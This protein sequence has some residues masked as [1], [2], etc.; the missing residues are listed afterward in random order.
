M[1]RSGMRLIASHYLHEA[2]KYPWHVAGLFVLPPLGVF[3]NAFASTYIASEI[4]DTLSRTGRVPL[5]QIWDTFGTQIIL[6]FA[7]IIAGELIIWRL[8]L[9]VV[10]RLEVRVQFA[11]FNKCFEYL[12]HQSAQFH[13]NKFGGS[14]VSQTNKFVS[15]YVRLADTIVFNVLPFASTLIFALVILGFRVPWF[16]V[17]LGVISLIFIGITIGSYSRIAKLN[18]AS[19]EASNKLSGQIADMISNILA[20]KSFS[21]EKSEIKRFSGLNKVAARIESNLMNATMKRDIGFAS[22][23]VA[24]LALMFGSILIGQATVGISIGTMI[25]MLTYSLSLFNQLWHVNGMARSYNRIYG[26]ALPMAE[27]LQDAIIIKDATKPESPLISKGEI[28]LKHVNF[29]YSENND[30]LFDDYNLHIPHGQRVGL[31]G[32]S[33]SGKTTLTNLLLRFNDID[34]GDITIDG[35]DIRAIRQ[36]DLRANIAYV[37]QQPL[38]FHR[39]LE[40]NIAYGRP[41]ASKEDIKKAAA[42]ANATEFIDKLSHGYDTLVGE[43]GVKLSGGQ[44][45]RIAIARAILKD[46]PILLLDEATS[47]LDSESEVLIQDALWKLMEGRTALVIAHRLSTIQKMDRIVVMDNGRIVEDGSHTELLKKKGVYAK[48]WSHQSGGFIED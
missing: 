26:D 34:G 44:R 13:A 47:A 27:I 42:K 28:E 19:S 15:S 12:S 9:F 23:L 40:E 31:V 46:A 11:L 4:I 24:L 14:L 5:N 33:G 3:C 48:L 43:R 30:L 45:Q 32:H 35:Q 39:S 6:F 22:S 10:W 7:A 16:S 37:P 18:K 17:G 38:L 2:K 1:K 21:A 20:V 25:L 8:V 29:G 36:E 41:G